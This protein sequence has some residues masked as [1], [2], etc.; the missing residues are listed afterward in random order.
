MK[1]ELEQLGEK[2]LPGKLINRARPSLRMAD[3]ILSGDDENSASQRIALTTFTI[4]VVSAFIALVSQ[5][6]LARWLG[7]FEYGIY[8]TIWVAVVIL[9]TLTC[10]GFPSAVV[11]F[12]GEYRE[13]KR[14][15]L[16]HGI[17]RASMFISL[18]VSLLI[19]IAGCLILYTNPEIATNYYIIPVYLAAICLPM[20]AIEG[21]MDCIARAFNW[22]K[23]LSC[24]L[25][26]FAL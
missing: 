23:S 22:Q 12:V 10:I 17:I 2:Y 5:I 16:I 20:L 8:V 24:R 25:I 4:R 13:R 3:A 6:L 7:T 9:S 15:D 26:S 18:L 1:I 11:R 21:V 14:P 19:A